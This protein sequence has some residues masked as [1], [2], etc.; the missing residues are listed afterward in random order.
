MIYT[1]HCDNCEER[2][3]ERHGMTEEPTVSCQNC[4][5]TM[6]KVIVDMPAVNWNGP[7][8]HMGGVTPLAKQMEAN[9]NKRNEEL[10]Q[11][12]GN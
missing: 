3:I 5:A 8:P 11:K 10:E 1:Y 2:Q 7:P 12:W 4:E 9:H 6:R